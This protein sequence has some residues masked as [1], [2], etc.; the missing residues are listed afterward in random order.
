MRNIHKQIKQ[1][2][3]TEK[4]R[5]I[6]EQLRIAGQLSNRS[7]ARIIGCSPTTVGAIRRELQTNNEQIGQQ[8]TDDWM[9]HPYFLE[10]KD[11]LLDGRLSV[12]SLRALCSTKVL[13]KMQEIGSLSPRYCQRLLYKEKKAANK[14]VEVTLNE[15]SVKVFQGDVRTGLIE[16]IVDNSVQLCF[17]DMPYHRKAIEEL[18]PH[19]ATTAARILS[20]GGSLLLMVGGSHLNKVI[21]LLATADKALRFQWDILYVCPRGTPLIQGRRVTTAVKHI[22]WMVKNKYTGP[23]Q[24]DLIYAPED[25]DG[26]DKEHHCWGQ[27]IE[28]ASELIKRFT[29]PGDLVCDMMVGGGSCA[30]ASVINNR[31]FI[32]CDIDN[33]A[34]R[35]TKQRVDKLFGA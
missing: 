2:K 24:Y 26:S 33:E 3:Q 25:T 22:L 11:K 12:K 7:L 20:D 10:N 18:T 32:G 15:S 14:A 13:D 17:V 35:I 30:V 34:V 21:P 23:I 8:N 27:S 1:L 31:R 9:K 4:R 6:T 29:I 5:V 28:T 19:I 16:D